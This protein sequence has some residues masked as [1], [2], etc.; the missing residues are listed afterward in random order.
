MRSRTERLGGTRGVSQRVNHRLKST[1]FDLVRVSQL[2]LKQSGRVFHADTDILC[3]RYRHGCDVSLAQDP[4]GTG[5]RD[6]EMGG[7]SLGV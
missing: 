7:K 6:A 3:L 4:R 2:V 1:F 5:L